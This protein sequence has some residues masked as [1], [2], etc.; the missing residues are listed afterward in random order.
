MRTLTLDELHVISAAAQDAQLIIF[1][2]M[3]AGAIGGAFLGNQQ[4]H[5]VA[6][7]ALI[8]GVMCTGI[9]ALII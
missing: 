8:G 4:K 9:S 5:I 3:A 2:G 6:A 7:G 1:S